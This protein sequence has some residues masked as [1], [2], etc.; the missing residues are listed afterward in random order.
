MLLF[1]CFLGTDL[2]VTST[3]YSCGRTSWKTGFTVM[4][5]QACFWLLLLC[6]LSLEIT[7]QR[8]QEQKDKCSP[9]VFNFKY[10]FQCV[11]AS[12]W[13]LFSCMV[14]IT[15]SQSIMC[16]RGCWR[17]WPCP[18][19]RKSCQDYMQVMPRCSLKRQKQSI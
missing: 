8:Y 14:R 17:S 10:Q 12:H 18:L 9:Y 16:P 3:T 13:C 2:L 4:R 7:C 19:L 11:T 1:F 5:R 15:T 6:R